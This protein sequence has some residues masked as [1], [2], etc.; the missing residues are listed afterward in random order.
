[1]VGFGPGPWEK[2]TL[3]AADLLLQ[4]ERIYFRD[5]TWEVYEHLERQGKR[6]F[7]L[8]HLY[9]LGLSY[10]EVY[11]MTVEILLKSARLYGPVVYAQ[12]GNPFVFEFSTAHLLAEAERQGMRVRVVEGMSCLDTMFVEHQLDP[13]HGLQILNMFQVL[14]GVPWTPQ[15]GALIFQVGAPIVGYGSN[16]LEI[17]RLQARLAQFYPPGHPLLL[18]R[19][20]ATSTAQERIPMQL[21]ELTRRTEEL[22]LYS[23][24]YVPA[25]G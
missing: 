17:M 14:Q 10:T 5:P 3:E 25:R 23:T 9:R 2:V 19:P 8:N 16:F 12:A 7:R 24:L 18:F 15:L 13:G 4:A 21:G 20:S 6:L 1:V 11:S 22:T